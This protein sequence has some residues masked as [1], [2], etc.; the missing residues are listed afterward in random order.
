LSVGSG[1]VGAAGSLLVAA[2]AAVAVAEAV[3]VGAV[4]LAAAVVA[5]D[6]G[7]ALGAVVGDSRSH[8]AASVSGTASQAA[9]IGRVRMA[10]G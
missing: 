3:A 7:S 1:D 5:L 4:T 9:E 2:E 8:A 10:G 6:L